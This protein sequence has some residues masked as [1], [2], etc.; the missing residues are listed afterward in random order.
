MLKNNNHYQQTLFLQ[1][2]ESYTP[3]PK[4]MQG[5]HYKFFVCRDIPTY[6]LYILMSVC[7]GISTGTFLCW[8]LHSRGFHCNRKSP[9]LQKFY[10]RFLSIK[11]LSKELHSIKTQ[12]V[13]LHENA[14]SYT[15]YKK[16]NFVARLGNQQPKQVYCQAYPNFEINVV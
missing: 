6:F 10:Y 2:I 7:I 12:E 5:C 8:K 14:G 1:C 16:G 4:Y 11:I 13:T 9:A 3:P 15:P